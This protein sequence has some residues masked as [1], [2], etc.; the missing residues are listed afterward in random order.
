MKLSRAAVELVTLIIIE[1][2]N[3]WKAYLLLRLVFRTGW[4]W[5]AVILLSWIFTLK[6]V[7]DSLR[8]RAPPSEQA[9]RGNHNA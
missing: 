2:L 9:S 6:D 4:T 1:I 7:I 3:L 5:A 8:V